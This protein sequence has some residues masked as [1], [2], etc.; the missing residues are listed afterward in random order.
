[1]CT[2]RK[3]RFINHYN[4]K[5]CSLLTICSL[6]HNKV[7]FEMYYY[8]KYLPFH[9]TRY[10]TYFNLLY[11][12]LNKTMFMTTFKKLDC[13]CNMIIPFH[14]IYIQMERDLIPLFNFF[15]HYLVFPPHIC[16]YTKGSKKLQINIIQC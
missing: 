6:I 16:I 12:F 13:V 15:F 10:Q 5:Y 2:R 8:R 14:Y 3:K 7:C 9:S 1:M 4:M 11:F